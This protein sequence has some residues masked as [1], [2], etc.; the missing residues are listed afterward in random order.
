M[1]FAIWITGLPGS[2]KS[3]ISKELA[4][5]IDAEILRLDE[6]RSELVPNPKFTDEER[7][8]VYNK[9]AEKGAKLS[10]KKN[11]I[12]DATDNLNIGRKKA[13]QLIKD[14]FVVQIECPIDLCE[15]RE[16]KRTDKAGVQNIYN[17]ARKDEIKIPGLNDKYIKEEKPLIII[18]SDKLTPLESAELISNKIRNI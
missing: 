10:E 2:G 16:N 6:F 17:R 3:T 13:K 1:P 14:F 11:V 9:L 15:E 8:L 7:K 12:F 5:K 4:K 18:N